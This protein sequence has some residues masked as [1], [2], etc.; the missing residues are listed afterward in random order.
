MA[1]LSCECAGC[2][3]LGWLGFCGLYSLYVCLIRNFFLTEL[4]SVM[5]SMCE[6]KLAL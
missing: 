3:E 5:L 1:L 4:E 6:F 2:W